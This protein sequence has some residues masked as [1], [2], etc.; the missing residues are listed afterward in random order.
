MKLFKKL[1]IVGAVCVVVLIV[2]VVVAFSLGMNA[3]AK[4]GIEQGGTYALGVNTT[5]D[6]ASV[7]IF[8]GKFGMRGFSV[9]NPEG[10]PSSHFLTL[11]NAGV[12][13]SM[14]SLQSDTIELPELR[15]ENIVANLEKKDGAANYQ[16]ILD[17]VKRRTGEKDP[18]APPSEDEGPN[19]VINDL[20]IRDVTVNMQVLGVTNITVPIDE[21][22]LKNVGRTGTGVRGTGVTLG[23]LTGII[24]QA[25]MAAAI[26]QGGDLIPRDL[27]GDMQGA[28][29]GLGSLGDMGLQVLGDSPV[30]VEQLGEAA[31]KAVEDV[32]DGV[33]GLIPG[34]RRG[35]NDD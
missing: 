21:I 11:G 24:V 4:Q 12:Q 20:I 19:L 15:L 17:N 5:V 6:S 13:V 10:F 27:V 9:A 28:L 33:R 7:G 2:G 35:N 8:S 23:E 22:R 25:V 16:V 14:G 18:S 1:L 3:I 29:A 26:Q 34:Q 32:V 30:K 31:Q